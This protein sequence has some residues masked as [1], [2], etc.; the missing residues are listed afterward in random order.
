MGGDFNMDMSSYDLSSHPELN[1]VPYRPKSGK[2]RGMKNT[3]LFTMDTIQ[4]REGSKN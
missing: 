3:F 1:L 2:N 4:V